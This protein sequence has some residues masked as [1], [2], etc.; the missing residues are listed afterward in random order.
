[1]YEIILLNKDGEKFSKKFASEFLYNK[2]LQKVKHSKVLTLISYG[3][4]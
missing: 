4:I 2:F 1:M 3:R